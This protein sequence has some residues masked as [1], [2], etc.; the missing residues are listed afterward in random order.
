MK[1][2]ALVINL[3]SSSLKAA[4]VDSTGAFN[5][6][7]DH[8]ITADENLSEVLQSWLEPTLEPLLLFGSAGGRLL[9]ACGIFETFGL[10][11][12]ALII[13]LL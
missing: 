13:F 7:G 1:D 4:L 5:W 11:I 8:R 3:G 10:S 2:L 12:L 6:H 9:D